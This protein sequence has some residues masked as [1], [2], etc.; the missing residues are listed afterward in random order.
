[1]AR[2]ASAIILLGALVLLLTV[3]VQMV[4]ASSSED[5][6]KEAKEAWASFKNYLHDQKHDAVQYGRKL[7]KKTETEIDE[8][9][10]K[11]GKASGEAKDEYRNS[12]ENLKQLRDKAA[13]KLDDLENSSGD[14]WDASKEGFAE[15]YD[16]LYKAYK[17]AAA[18][19]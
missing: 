2:N 3:P 11:A 16:D 5:V 1:M 19:F 4:T 10:A 9:E 18:K 14:A 15:A 13:K 7:L 8:L 17:E 6:K 12:I